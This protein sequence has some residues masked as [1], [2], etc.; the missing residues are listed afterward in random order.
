MTS[1]ISIDSKFE[2]KMK[3]RMEDERDEERIH[4]QLRE[5]NDEFTREKMSKMPRETP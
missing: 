2:Q 3:K 5:I 4:K 1:L